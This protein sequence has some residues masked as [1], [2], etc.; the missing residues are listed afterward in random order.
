M[1]KMVFAE[2]LLPEGWRRN[3][4]V[5]IDAEGR[6]GA[7]V[8]DAEPGRLVAIPGLPNLHSHAF[9]RGMA[10][11]TEHA[12]DSEDSFWTWRELMYRFLAHLTPEDV[13]AI[14]I[15]AYAEMLEAGF[16][17]VGEF[18][19]LHHAPGGA[20]YADRAEMA[21]RIA[22][23]A[24]A[25]GINLTLLPCFYAHGEIGGAPP[26]AG[27]RRFLNGLD[28]FAALVEGSRRAI[29]GLPGSNL[30]LA[31]H[32]L[33]AATIAEIGA[34]ATMAQPGEPLH[35]HAAEQAKE[36]EASLRILGLPPIAALLEAGLVD[37]RWCLIHA[38]HGTAAE[39]TRVAQAGAVVGLCPV[40]ESNLGDGIFPAVAY[41]AA[42]GRF[43]VGTDSN[44]LVSAAMELRTLEYS[45]RLAQRTRNAL[46]PRGGSTAR[47]LW[48]AAVAG[49]TQ[50]LAAGPAGI[51]PGAHADLV[52][53]DPDHPA[54][55]A[56]DGDRRL[57]TLL[58]ASR[59]GAIREVWVRG[60]RVVEDGT[61]SARAAAERR[62]AATLARILTT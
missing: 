2:A 22:A 32:S 10:G 25:T 24:H 47:A 33:R 4:R 6:I 56:R 46:A 45:Q 57:D 38:T 59:E 15:L 48:Q 23:A 28:G 13:E 21:V 62:V 52:L 49:G 1:R 20:P 55:A 37:A 40:T 54:F 58:F 11:L 18:H 35:I 26:V 14:A 16:T 31:P 42:G 60:A 3:V 29:A 30:G 7:V 39:L 51:V 8:P 17:R 43:G 12:G 34:V 5:E 53:L 36:V 50:A 44:V 9:Q 41:R 19:Y 61:H 27:Q